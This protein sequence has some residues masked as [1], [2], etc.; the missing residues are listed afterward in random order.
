MDP[1]FRAGLYLKAMLQR[2]VLKSAGR[3]A[4]SADD[5]AKSLE[6]LKNSDAQRPRAEFLFVVA[7]ALYDQSALFGSTKLDQPNRLRLMCQEATDALQ[8]VPETKETKALG[9]K[10]QAALKKLKT[11]T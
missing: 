11:S 3:A 6:V 2:A 10:I 5:T 7:K 1:G 9:A 4:G 8:A